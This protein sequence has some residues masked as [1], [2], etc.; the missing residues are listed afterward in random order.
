M[1]VNFSMDQLRTKVEEYTKKVGRATGRPVLTAYYVMTADT[2]PE[3]ERTNIMLA[4]IAIVF[5]TSIED[6]L[7]QIFLVGKGAAA[8][9]AYKKIKK[10]ITPQIEDK[11]EAKLDE[12]F[13]DNVT[14]VELLY[15]E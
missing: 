12:W 9:Y 8:V 15:L 4:L 1:K 7:G 10:Y 3:S 5:P 14:E 11:V 2:T 6:L 13:H